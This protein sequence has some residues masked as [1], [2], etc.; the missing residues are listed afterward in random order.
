MGGLRGLVPLCQI[1]GKRPRLPAGRV[2]MAGMAID[3]PP[4]KGSR[5]PVERATGDCRSQCDKAKLGTQRLMLL[6]SRL[7]G[8]DE[9]ALIQAS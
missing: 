2:S 4:G 8:S 5:R 1:T 7:R 6:G 3:K 9:I